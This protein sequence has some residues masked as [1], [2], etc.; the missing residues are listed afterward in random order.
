MLCRFNTKPTYSACRAAIR[1]LRYVKATF[2]YG[3]QYSG[4]R[5]NPEGYLDSDWGNDLDTG[6]ST[7]G[8]VLRL[9]N[10]LWRHR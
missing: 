8:Y 1:L 3:I 6:R 9:V 7:T 4:H 2:D 10:R 5:L